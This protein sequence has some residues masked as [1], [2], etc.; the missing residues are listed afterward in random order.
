MATTSANMTLRAITTIL[1]TLKS[2]LYPL[3]PYGVLFRLTDLFPPNTTSPL[4]PPIKIS[5][6]FF[7]LRGR[8]F[9]SVRAHRRCVHGP[10]GPFLWAF[11]SPPIWAFW[12]P[13]IWAL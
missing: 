11:W 1:R 6:P 10:S 5:F 7:F 13:L 2:F 3:H 4:S 9:L 8:H 12:S